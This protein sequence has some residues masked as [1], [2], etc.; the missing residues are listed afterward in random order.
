MKKIIVFLF[1]LSLLV[2]SY[3]EKESVLEIKDV[4]VK[5]ERK[6]KEE[7][8]VKEVNNKVQKVNIVYKDNTKETLNLEDYVVGVVAC[9]MPASFNIEALKAMAVAARTFA[10]YKIE[11]NK[12]YRL[13]TTTKDQCYIT[14]EQMKKNW[15]NSFNKNYNRVLKSV[16]A[17]KNE[18]MTY[19][20]K[21]IISFYFS[22][23]NG[24]TENCEDVFSQKLPY[25]RSVDS[26]WDKDYSYKEKT[27][28]LSESEFLKELDLKDN[29]V[30]SI[31]IKK[32]K[33]NRARYVYI[34]NNKFTG[35]KVRS[36]LHLR[37]TD[38]SITNKNGYIYITTKGYGHGVGMSQYGAQSM[39]KE[40]YKYDEILKY[41]YKGIELSA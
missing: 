15:G 2:I 10:L 39:A 23:S 11:H 1:V 14:K 41:Y 3:K 29:K 8:I 27:I 24:Y 40:G 7:K 36:L 5:E 13:S 32:D 20:D 21:T 28:K 18:R 19:N 4:N 37:S 33:K 35:T 26:H 34:N 22:I 25:L 12:N 9:E 17:T 30:N 6:K 38:I 31:K 16:N